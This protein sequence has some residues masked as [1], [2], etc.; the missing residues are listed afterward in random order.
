VDP[1][2]EGIVRA[3]QNYLGDH[4]T[5]RRVVPILAH[6]DAS[7]TGQGIISETLSLSQLPY[8]RTGGTIHVIVNNQIGFT[9]LPRQGRFT[10]YPTDVAKMIQAPIFHVNGD[11]P[12][13]CVHVA[14]WRSPSARNSAWT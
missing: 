1:V 11:D 12:E 3:K 9:T 6:G 8:Y 7:F 5:R 10:P 13:A 2:V 14:R 4:A